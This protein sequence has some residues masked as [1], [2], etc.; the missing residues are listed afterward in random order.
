MYNE[1]HRLMS[2]FSENMI[3]SL[4]SSGNSGA[5]VPSKTLEEN[6]SLYG[7]GKEIF[8]S[9]NFK[10]YSIK[11]KYINPDNNKLTNKGFSFLESLKV[12]TKNIEEVK[13]KLLEKIKRQEFKEENVD[14]NFLK[15]IKNEEIKLQL[16]KETKQI[17]KR[18]WIFEFKDKNGNNIIEEKYN[19]NKPNQNIISIKSLKKKT[20][21][22][23]IKINDFKEKTTIEV[24]KE[25]DIRNPNKELDY[26]II[27]D[28]DVIN[29]NTLN[30]LK[31]IINDRH[32]IIDIKNNKINKGY[33]KY[34]SN[35]IFK[36]ISLEEINDLINNINPI[37]S[38]RNSKTKVQE[39]QDN[40]FN[41][42][43]FSL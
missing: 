17:R 20:L 18:N 8:I 27:S 19:P 37:N 4:Y 35:K 29:D 38:K 1:I 26:L 22:K 24:Y 34:L 33:F 16:E 31:K 43:N 30:F 21:E 14:F 41:I 3:T 5:G 9:K 42:N 32:H 10:E 6:F 13:T 7:T 28:I 15:M 2:Q 39:K 23:I 40:S 36:E 11:N 12:K 25:T